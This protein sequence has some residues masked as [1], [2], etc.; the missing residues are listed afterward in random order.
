MFVGMGML[1][2]AKHPALRSLAEVA[3]IGMMSV[4][5]MA[6]VFPSLLF[7]LLT[8]RKGKKRLMPVTLKNLGGMIYSFLYFLIM[9]LIITIYGWTMFTFGRATEKKKL[10]Y[11]QLLHRIAK[12][13][14]YHVPQVGTTFRNLSDETFEKPGIIICNH[15]AHLDLMCI[16][17][18]TPKLIILTNDWVWNSPFYGRLIKYL[19]FYP[20]SNGFENAMDRLQ[21]AIDRG[22][23]IVVFPEGTRSADCSIRRFHRGP[24]YLAEKMKLDIIPILIHGVGHVLPKEEFMLRKGRIHIQVMPRIAPDD[25]RFSSDYSPR[26]RDVRHYYQAE[27]KKLCD[28]LETPDYYADLVMKNYIYKGAAIERE[29]RRNLKKNNNYAAE[30]AAQPDEGEVTIQNTGYGEYALLLS[31]VRKDLCITAI[32]PDPDRRALAG[33]CASVPENLHFV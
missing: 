32:E 4:V 26:S 29:V 28:E 27:Y 18:L 14:I 1:I 11:H 21:D 13:V 24:F 6:Y 3:M 7:R 15:Q 2:F 23:S 9:S 19:D 8:V 5:I 20:L 25:P 33:N 31:L 30:I 17:M 22:Y 10:R 16:M 12:F